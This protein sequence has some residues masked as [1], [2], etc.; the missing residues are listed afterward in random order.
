MQGR[1]QSNVVGGVPEMLGARGQSP[2]N[3]L[4]KIGLSESIRNVKTGL[5]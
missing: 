4:Q 1:I 3:F 2:W 5:N